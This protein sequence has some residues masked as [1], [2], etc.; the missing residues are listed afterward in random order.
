MA[1]TYEP[2]PWNTKEAITKSLMNHIENGIKSTADQANANEASIATLKN[3]SESEDSALWNAFGYGKVLLQDK[4]IKDYIDELTIPTGL[5]DAVAALQTEINNAHDN[6]N[7]LRETLQIIRDSITAVDTRVRRADSVSATNATSINDAKGS[8]LTL[9]DRI[10]S[11][12]SDNDR[13]KK[14]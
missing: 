2:H 9:K 14:S 3:A 10:D 6:G 7:P 5:T 1:Y 13:E 11:I 4:T 12:V 8:S